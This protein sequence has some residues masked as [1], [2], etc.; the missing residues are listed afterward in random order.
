MM[1]ILVPETC[2]GNKTAYFAASSWFFTFTKSKMHGHRNIKANT[3]TG[4]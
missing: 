3:F 1:G 4:C 2:W